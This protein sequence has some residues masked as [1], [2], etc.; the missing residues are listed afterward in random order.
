[1]LCCVFYLRVTAEIHKAVLD[2]HKPA[3][4]D[5]QQQPGGTCGMHPGCCCL[6]ATVELNGQAC[7]CPKLPFDNSAIQSE[8]LLMKLCDLTHRNPC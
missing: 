6:F 1:M 4:L 2:K 7:A 3:D 5:E 8:A